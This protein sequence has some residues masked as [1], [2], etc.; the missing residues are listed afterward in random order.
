MTISLYLQSI[1]ST[2]AFY[3]DEYVVRSPKISA[4]GKLANMT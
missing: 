3:C 1:E 2:R 4:G